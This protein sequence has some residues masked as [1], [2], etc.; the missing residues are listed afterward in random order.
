VLVIVP[1]ALLV[2]IANPYA[3]LLL[4]PGANLLL[5][6]SAAE[7]RPRRALA[8]ALVACSF[9]PL[10][11]LL[12]FYADQLGLGPAA[13]AFFAVL[14]VAGGHVGLGAALLWSV[15]GG[16][17]VAAVRVAVTRPKPPALGE[18]SIG[19]LPI[20]IRGPLTYAGPGSLGGTQSALR[21]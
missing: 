18:A 4:A 10:A 14:N 15:A 16:A 5:A 9:A 2:W 3:A 20:T 21:R 6:L 13:A 11:L 1:L 17:A 19:D 8:L 7:W 12:A